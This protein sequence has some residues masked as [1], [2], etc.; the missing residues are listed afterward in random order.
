MGCCISPLSSLDHQKSYFWDRITHM[1]EQ[2]HG[3]PDWSKIVQGGE[4]SHPF[5]SISTPQLRQGRHFI[6]L[7]LSLTST[8]LFHLGPE[9]PRMMLLGSRKGCNN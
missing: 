6:L 7:P 5:S 2:M 8:L 4:I 1:E 9:T 3:L